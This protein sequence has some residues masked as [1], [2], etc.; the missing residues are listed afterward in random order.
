MNICPKTA[1]H[2]EK[3]EYGFLYPRIDVGKCVECG[4]C[5]KVCAFQNELARRQPQRVYAIASKNNDLVTNSAS[6]GLFATMAMYVLEHGGCV[7]GAIMQ[8][9]EHELHIRHACCETKEDL[10]RFQGSKYVQSSLGNIFKDIQMKLKNDILVLFS[11]TPCQVDALK[12]F[13]KKE[14]SNLLTVDIVC[15]GVPNEQIFNDYIHYIEKKIGGE[16]REFKFRDK[17]LGWGYNLTAKYIQEDGSIRYHRTASSDSSYF[18]MF[19]N[20]IILRENCY[21]CKY[22]NGKRTGDIT[23]GDYWGIEDEHPEALEQN[24]GRLSEKSGIS[25]SF[26]NSDKGISFFDEIKEQFDYYESTFEKVAKRNTQL[27]HPVKLTKARGNVLEMY[28]KWGYGAVEFYFWCRIPKQKAKYIIRKM[29][30]KEAR[31]KIKQMLH[32]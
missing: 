6:G 20:S 12:L 19:I 7:Y 32:R 27:V 9:E 30:P 23:I 3:D 1:I 10:Y 24:G 4:A 5:K 8:H 11:G 21:H 31:Q 15:H 22:T 17:S 13:L 29:L 14:Y 16:I 25:V 28:R 26:L 2:M 18:D